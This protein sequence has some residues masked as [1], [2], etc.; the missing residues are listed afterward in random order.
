MDLTFSD[1]VNTGAIYVV[2]Y[3]LKSWG[4]NRAKEP[5]LLPYTVLTPAKLFRM[6]STVIISA[7]SILL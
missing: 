1:L 6:Y 5:K 7:G 2:Y 3:V 4:N